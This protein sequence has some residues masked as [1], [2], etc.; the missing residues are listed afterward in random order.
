MDGGADGDFLFGDA[1]ADILDGGTGID[2][3]RGGDDSDSYYV[4]SASDSVIE[5]AGAAAGTADIIYSSVTRTIAANVE[6]LTLTGGANINGTG[7]NLANDT[8][9]GNIGNNTLSG[10]S[11]NDTLNGGLGDDLLIGGLGID[12]LIGGAGIDTASYAASTAAVTVNL[13]ADTGV[14]GEAQGDKFSLIEN[15]IGSTKADSLT[16]NALVNVLDGGVDALADTLA[17][18]AGNDTYIIRSATDIIVEGVGG[19]TA[20]RAKL[21]LSFALAAD[22]NIE[23]LETLA[24]TAATAINLTGSAIAQTI[25]GNAGI[26]ILDGGV[27]ALA[28]TLFG[29]LGND[30]YV[31]RSINDIIVESVGQGAADRVKTTVNFVL[32]T[33]ANIEFLETLTPAAATA[34]S[35]TGNIIA[36]TI[37]GNA[38]SNIINGKSGNDTLTGGAGND[39]FVFDTNPHITLNRDSITDFNVANDTIRIENSVFIGVANVGASL[40]ASMFKAGPATDDNDFILYNSASGRL[41]YDVDGNGDGVAIQFASVAPNTALTA[42]DCVV[43]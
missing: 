24:P 41:Y 20:D 39:F 10:F 35:L 28:D 37:T 16:G 3:L 8:I 2:Q 25:T 18:G 14:G 13:L 30:T 32:A 15:L 38:G 5:V 29:G 34:I 27:D 6:R 19:G 1:G 9:T 21:A 12:S 36:Q 31:I 40:N 33:S 43:I 7:L 23:F 11:G 4:D 17:G 22:D 42:T 26:N